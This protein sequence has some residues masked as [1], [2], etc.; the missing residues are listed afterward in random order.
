MIDFS[1]PSRT[2]HRTT[3]LINKKDWDFIHSRGLKPTNLLRAKIQELKKR[4]EGSCIDYEAANARLRDKLERI[5]GA[6]EGIL[7][8]EQVQKIL[9]S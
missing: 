4:E 2:A 8:Q 3:I 9:N 7:T 5:C 6:M 1:P